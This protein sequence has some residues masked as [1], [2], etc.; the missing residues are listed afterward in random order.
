MRDGLLWIW[1]VSAGVL[2]L[3]ALSAGLYA[4]YRSCRQWWRQKQIAKLLRETEYPME[5]GW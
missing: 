2:G 3:F 4:G 1:L 5:Q